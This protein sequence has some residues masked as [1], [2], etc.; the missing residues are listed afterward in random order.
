MVSYQK[1][2]SLFFSEVDADGREEAT[3][4]MQQAAKVWNENKDELSTATVAETRQA[5]QQL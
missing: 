3:T 1:F 4:A 5:L 2:V